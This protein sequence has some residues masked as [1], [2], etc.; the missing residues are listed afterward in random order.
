MKS[1]KEIVLEQHTQ[2][3]RE[4]GIDDYSREDM[5]VGASSGLD[6][7]GIVDFIIGI[8]GELNI[9]LDESLGEIRNSKTI[10]E[11]ILEAPISGKI[12]KT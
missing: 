5:E 12:K 1:V 2:I 3:M 6:S 8:E 11:I 7:L 4:N 10:K 9:E